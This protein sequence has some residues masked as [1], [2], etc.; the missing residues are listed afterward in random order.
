MKDINNRKDLLLST[1]AQNRTAPIQ[2][3]RHIRHILTPKHFSQVPKILRRTPISPL[4]GHIIQRKRLV[5]R[6]RKDLRGRQERRVVD[7]GVVVQRLNRQ[8]VL[9]G[10]GR[11]VDADEAVGRAGDEQVGRGWVEA[12]RGDVVAVDFGVGCFGG[13]GG[14]DVPGFDELFGVYR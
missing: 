8:L 12:E 9:V 3:C 2:L 14:A 7:R 11:V 10:D 4:L 13:G 6:Q 1:R 5:V